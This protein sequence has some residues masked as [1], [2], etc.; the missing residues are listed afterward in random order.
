MQSAIQKISFW[1]NKDRVGTCR[2]MKTSMLDNTISRTI[3]YACCV[4]ETKLYYFMTT[5]CRCCN[6]FHEAK[7]AKF[8]DW[9]KVERTFLFTDELKSEKSSLCMFTLN[10]KHNERKLKRQQQPSSQNN[11]ALFHSH[12]MH[13]VRYERLCCLAYT[14]VLYRA[15]EYSCVI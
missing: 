8:T 9:R 1:I 11:T 10:V 3:Q 15:T 4:G 13:I 7:R 2:T 5:A 6:F 12:S 14:S